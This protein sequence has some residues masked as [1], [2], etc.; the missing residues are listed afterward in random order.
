MMSVKFL[1]ILVYVYA[2]GMI[3]GARITKAIKKDTAGFS[4]IVCS[5]MSAQL[6][7]FSLLS[8]LFSLLGQSLKSLTIVWGIL[9]AL[10]LLLF[11]VLD[12]RSLIAVLRD[13]MKHG[14]DRV[15]NSTIVE[16]LLGILLVLLI[17]VQIALLQNISFE[18]PNATRQIANAT[19]ASQ[20]G[21]L[22]IRTPF[23]MLWAMLADLCGVH[24]LT[25]IFSMLP[26]LLLPYFYFSYD[27]AA[28]TLFKDSGIKRLAMVI[29]V[30]LLQ[31]YG[32][33]SEAA[34]AMT[35]FAAYFGAACLL[36]HGMCPILLG[37]LIEKE[38]SSSQMEFED[39]EE[40]MK[41]HK[42]LNIKNLSVIFAVFM[43]IAGACVVILNQ[44][45]NNL[46]QATL[47]LQRSIEEA[48]SIHEF[49]GENQETI[50]GYLMK[51]GTGELVMI[52]GGNEKNGEAL[53][54]FLIAYG[55]KIDQW[56][57]YSEEAKDR[58][59]YDYCAGRKELEIGEVY[60]LQGLE[61]L[62]K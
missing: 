53:Y 44:K 47:A 31:L 62:K 38:I 37:I 15:R 30:A 59:A 2:S 29:L 45:I 26:Y 49:K 14:I 43:L 55:N 17:V 34:I 8:C 42:L 12:R 18:F 16:K 36:L 60:Y 48:C 4:F 21:I 7:L 1:L 33:Q 39:G 32:Y 50:D 13:S 3:F 61:E 24:V 40:D 52:G 56:Y 35:L 25:F 20:L 10:M 28:G 54:D 23:M 46:H 58:G 19:R 41:K 11:I 57:L 51:T 27:Y 22:D 9:S 6:I 5:G